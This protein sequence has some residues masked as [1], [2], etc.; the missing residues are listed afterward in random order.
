MAPLGAAASAY[1]FCE[2]RDSS[3]IESMRWRPDLVVGDF[4]LDLGW[5]VDELVVVVDE[6]GPSG[7]AG[8]DLAR[9]RLVLRVV[10]GGDGSRGSEPASGAWWGCAG[11]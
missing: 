3:S 8:A 2:R 4:D 5:P 11:S 1:S 9:G 10:S 6:G 7:A